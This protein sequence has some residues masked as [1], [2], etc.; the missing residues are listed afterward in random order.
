MSTIERCCEPLLNE[1]LGAGQADRLAAGFK[2]LSD[3]TRL[4]ILSLV[5]NAPAGELC[6][7][8]LPAQLGRSQP[9]VSHHLTLLTEAGLLSRDQRGKW[10]WFRIEPDRVAILRAALDL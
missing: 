4:R 6:A 9:T 10:A 3:P 7:C 1:P 8:D 5:A 2:L